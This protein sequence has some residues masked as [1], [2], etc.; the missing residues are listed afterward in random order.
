MLGLVLV[1]A[2]CSGMPAR[3]SLRAP[4]LSDLSLRVADPAVPM[5]PVAEWNPPPTGGM[6]LTVFNRT[7]TCYL[8][9]GGPFEP[10]RAVD[11]LIELFGS[12]DNYASALAAERIELVVLQSR[13]AVLGEPLGYKELG[14]ISLAADEAAVMRAAVTSDTAYDWREVQSDDD[15]PEYAFRVKLRS[16]DRVVIV[17]LSMAPMT[18]RVV[19]AGREVARQSFAFGY[20]TVVPL[21]ERHFP[22]GVDRRR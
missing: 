18:A 16:R 3:S 4:D 13:K 15:A 17:D 10:L 8:V 1:L 20:E 14:G 21:L 7:T 12:T 2:G 5:Q 19:V 6:S 9:C 22:G 11:G